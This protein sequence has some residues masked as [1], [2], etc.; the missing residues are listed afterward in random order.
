MRMCVE[1]VC[2]C[3]CKCAR[4]S[5]AANLTRNP[6]RMSLFSCENSDFRYKLVSFDVSFACVVHACA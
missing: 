4:Q 3:M 1:Y 5:L 2:A 6:T